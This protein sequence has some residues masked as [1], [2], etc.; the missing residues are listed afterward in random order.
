MCGEREAALSRIQPP[1][2]ATVPRDI[3]G[4]IE[5]F[6]PFVLGSIVR[7]APLL[8]DCWF[9]AVT[10]KNFSKAARTF[11][12]PLGASLWQDYQIISQS[13]RYIAVVMDSDSTDCYASVFQVGRITP[14]VKPG[15]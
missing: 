5:V 8:G 4:G 3:S 1:T 15:I 2:G 10:D 14:P 13:D 9:G 7:V 6:G 11:G 12:A